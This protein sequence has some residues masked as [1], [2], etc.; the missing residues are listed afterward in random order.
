MKALLTFRMAPYPLSCCELLSIYYITLR[1]YIYFFDD[2]KGV[3]TSHH[4]CSWR[5]FLSSHWLLMCCVFVTVYGALS[6]KI[7]ERKTSEAWLV[8]W[9]RTC[10]IHLLNVL[11]TVLFGVICCFTLV[12]QRPGQSKRQGG[13]VAKSAPKADEAVDAGC[14]WLQWTMSPVSLMYCKLANH[15]LSEESEE[16]STDVRYG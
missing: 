9:R 14:R 6:G 7:E 4:S 5:F 1:T 15:G 12:L 10:R 16:L 13:D 8:G 2:P 3:C 11:P